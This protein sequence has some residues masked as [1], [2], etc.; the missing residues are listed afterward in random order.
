MIAPDFHNGS[1]SG[2]YIL[3]TFPILTHRHEVKWG[4]GFRRMDLGKEGPVI[5]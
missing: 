5:S 3:N 1:K 4:V 2:S